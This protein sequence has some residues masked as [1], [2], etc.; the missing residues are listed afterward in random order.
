MS[1]STLTDT[2]IENHGMC[3]TLKKAG[4]LMNAE[5]EDYKD[6]SEGLAET[7]R[8][9]KW[10]LIDLNSNYVIHPNFQETTLFRAVLPL[11]G[12]ML[13]GSSIF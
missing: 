3:K 2:I 12:K 13:H 7:K 10:G 11:C 1:R 5:I 8:N 4:N 9:G 6:F